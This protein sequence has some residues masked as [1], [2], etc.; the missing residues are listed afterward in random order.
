MKKIRTMIKV[1]K[2]ANI[3]PS[4]VFFM[5]PP[6]FFIIEKKNTWNDNHKTKIGK[7]YTKM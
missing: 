2:Q 7:Q 5:T 4:T 1:P 6:I 3:K